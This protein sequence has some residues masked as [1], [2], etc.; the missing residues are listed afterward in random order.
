MERIGFF[1]G[2]FDPFTKGH[3]DIFCRALPLFDKIIIGVGKNTLKK[4]FFD[5]ETRKE[6]IEDSIEK[7][8]TGMGWFRE[9]GCEIYNRYEVVDYD[10][11]TVNACENFGSR[12]IIRG[13]R[14]MLDFENERAIADANKKIKPKID[15]LI[16]PTKQEFGHISSTAVRDL[17]IHNKDIDPFQ[18]H[19]FMVISKDT[20]LEYMN[21]N[22]N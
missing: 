16:L 3:L 4:G 5:V 1:P 9:D 6:I 11:L 2:S 13:V 17:L 21:K 15:T 20:L 19:D 7:Y 18:I 14:N 12:F 10:C 22:K 8:F